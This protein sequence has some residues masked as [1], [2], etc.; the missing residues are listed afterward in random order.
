MLVSCINLSHF[1]ININSTCINLV[2]K[3]DFDVA[4]LVRYFTQFKHE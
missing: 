4:I 1:I 3:T 2:A